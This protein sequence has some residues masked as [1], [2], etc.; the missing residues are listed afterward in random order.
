MGPECWQTVSLEYNDQL[1]GHV[2]VSC[3]DSIMCFCSTFI[4]ISVVG[5]VV[6]HQPTL[7]HGFK[8]RVLCLDLVV[9]FTVHRPH[10]GY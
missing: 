7:M 3:E 8:S 2:Q 9:A 5:V 10:W 6:A 4:K 1:L